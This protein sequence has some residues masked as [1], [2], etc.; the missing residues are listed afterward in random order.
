MINNLVFTVSTI[1]VLLGTL[2][3]LIMD[4]F[5]LGKYSVGPRTSMPSLCR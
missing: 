2:F 5:S 3:P 4:A 1:V